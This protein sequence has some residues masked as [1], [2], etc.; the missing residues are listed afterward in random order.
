MAIPLSQFINTLKT[1][2]ADNIKEIKVL[3]TPSSLKIINQ[4]NSNNKNK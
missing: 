1:S 4:I 2:E 3:P